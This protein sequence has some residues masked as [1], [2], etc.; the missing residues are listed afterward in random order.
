MKGAQS[1]WAHTIQGA[2]EQTGSLALAQDPRSLYGLG[3]LVSS[4]YPVQREP[5]PDVVM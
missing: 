1:P 4:L 3:A 5:M 2:E